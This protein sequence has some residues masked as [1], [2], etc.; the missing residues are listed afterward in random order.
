MAIHRQAEPGKGAQPPNQPASRAGAPAP[1][2]PRRAVAPRG[3]ANGGPPPVC[4]QP[5]QMA[6]R[7][8]CTGPA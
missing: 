5:R 7:P 6:D 3:S 4:P 2:H 8:S 1:R